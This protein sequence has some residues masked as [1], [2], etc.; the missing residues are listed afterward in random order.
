MADFAV[1]LFSNNGFPEERIEGDPLLSQAIPQPANKASLIQQMTQLK[2]RLT[3]LWTRVL[4]S[5]SY[6]KT[7]HPGLGYFDASEWLRFAEMHMR[8]HLRQK[9]RIEDALQLGKV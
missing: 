7:K 1:R 2:T 3:S 8:H 4:K 5:N 6:G 9:G